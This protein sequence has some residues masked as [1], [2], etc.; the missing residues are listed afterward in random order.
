MRRVREALWF[1]AS[2]GDSPV[3]HLIVASLSF[4]GLLALAACGESPPSASA[5]PGDVPVATPADAAKGA[6]A[7]P[8]G[9]TKAQLAAWTTRLERLARGF[10][11]LSRVDDMSHWAPA[12]CR[13]PM[14]PAS[15][16]SSAADA[17]SSD[18]GQ[19]IYAL[20]AA[21]VGAYGKLTGLWLETSVE[22]RARAGR[23]SGT[24]GCD[25]VIV[26]ESFEA[27][28]MAAD[29]KDVPFEGEGTPPGWR[30]RRPATR[31]GKR[32]RPGAA[33]GLFVMLH[34]VE[35]TPEADNGWIYGTVD[36]DGVVTSVGRVESCMGCHRAAPHGRLFGLAREDN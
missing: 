34:L 36:L 3:S 17:K 7:V 4:A 16:P 10:R 28:E 26:K 20:W 23:V 21:D 11:E 32:Y 33:K 27:V 13:R 29:A 19:K 1:L 25:Q 22:D 2:D 8:S 31:D 35:P 30:G 14:R 24:D 12:A 9:P 5:G 15:A 6:A 18:H